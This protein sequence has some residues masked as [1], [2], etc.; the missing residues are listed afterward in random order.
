M[1]HLK[2]TIAHAKDESKGVRT[3][4]LEGRI[5][6]YQPGNFFRLYLFVNGKR[7]F[8]PYSA[9]SHP[10]EK[11][12]RLCIKRNGEFSSKIWELE[13]GSTVELDGPHGLFLLGKNDIERV[14]IAGGVGITPLRPMIIQ[15]LIEG[16]RA[17]FF[18]TAR[19]LSEITYIGEMKMLE[20]QNPLFKYHPTVTR[21]KLPD[22]WGGMQMRLS[23]Q[24]IAGKL[25][26]LSGKTF[27]ICGARGMASSLA[28]ELMEAG[29]ARE[30]IRKEEWG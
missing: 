9:A 15:T 3:L 26:G 12:L 13:E 25:G 29:V 17:T 20:A 1:E 27:Y 28:K 10:S 23:A 16:K 5:P 7:T 11:Q 30:N 24:P 19:T 8:R 14:F 2:L 22:G 18:H 6:P 21:E 4:I